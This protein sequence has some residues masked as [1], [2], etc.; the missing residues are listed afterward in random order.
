MSCGRWSQSG[1]L[2]D[3]S[4]N[5]I[6]MDNKVSRSKSRCW[7][8][9]IVFAALLR[10]EF[11]GHAFL[12]QAAMSQMAASVSE[13]TATQEAVRSTASCAG[14]SVRSKRKLWSGERFPAM[15]F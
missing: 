1:V 4:A 2:S 13:M 3:V 7:D 5:R 12:L 10:R 8:E 9:L 14:S 11:P 6:T 15:A